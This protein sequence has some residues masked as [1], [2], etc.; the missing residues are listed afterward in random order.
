MDV[1]RSKKYSTSLSTTLN[2]VRYQYTY[3]TSNTIL[4][5]FE[6][7]YD[8]M[9]EATWFF[10]IVVV[11][12]NKMGRFKFVW[13][14]ENWMLPQKKIPIFYYCNPNL[15][16]VSKARACKSASQ[17]WIPRL[18]FHTPGSVGECEGM[19]PYTPKWAP[20]LGIGVPMDS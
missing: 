11:P 2:W 8:P 20:I 5:E 18:I 10:P 17:E 15:G 14:F 9:K 7:H 3:I 19:N 4:D 6:L 13:I 16:F 12:K 1:Q